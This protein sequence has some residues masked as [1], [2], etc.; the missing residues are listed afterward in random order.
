MFYSGVFFVLV[1]IAFEN[2]VEGA[3]QTHKGLPLQSEAN[4]LVACCD[5]VRSAHIVC[6][7]CSLAEVSPTFVVHDLIFL[8]RAWNIFSSNGCSTADQEELIAGLAL[9]YDVIVLSELLLLH[10]IAKRASLVRV[11][12]L[13]NRH[14]LQERVILFAFAPIL[15]VSTGCRRVALLTELHLSQCC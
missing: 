7:E 6:E 9:P 15:R 5:N 12:A 14:A 1:H 2:V 13:Q 3:K 11:H 4:D 10:R 8:V